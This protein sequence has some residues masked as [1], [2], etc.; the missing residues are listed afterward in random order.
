MVIDPF[1]IGA[2]AAAVG[3]AYLNWR[4]SQEGKAAAENASEAELAAI[5]E[6]MDKI[7]REWSLPEYDRKPLTPEEYQLLGTYAPQVASYIE[8]K[9]PTMLQGVGQQEGLAAQREALRRFTEMSGTG[10]DVAS[11][12]AQEQAMFRAS[13]QARANRQQ[14]L[15]ELS[16]RGLGGTGQELVA[17]QAGEQAIAD[18]ARQ[19]A[20]EAQQQAQARRMAALQ[21]MS[22]IGQNMRQMAAQQEQ[23]NVGALNDFN[24]RATMS[25]RAWE[26]YRTGLMNEA[27]MQNLQASQAI[28]NQNVALRN[29]AA[30]AN[31][32]RAD[33]IT[34][35]L[36][37]AKNRKLETQAGLMGKQATTQATGIKEAGKAEAEGMASIAS[38]IA[39]TPK[40][41]GEAKKAFSGTETDPKKKGK[42]YED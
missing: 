8:E 39:A 36:T 9:A 18:Q 30:L 40:M 28:A 3:S 26:Q 7:E 11:Q 10:E 19:A 14:L 27:Q 23:A 1:T 22:G 13:Q 34:E 42:V 6:V 37:E 29:Q 32:T 38:G 16:Q 12:A 4:A 2:V 24:Q 25:R 20:L 41:V 15:Q 35:A 17:A 31:Q 33:K 5:K 21:Q